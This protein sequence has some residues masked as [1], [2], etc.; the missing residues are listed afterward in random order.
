MIPWHP[1]SSRKEFLRALKFG[2]RS[3]GGHL[4]LRFLRGGAGLRIGFS[5]KSGFKNAARRN[6]AKRWMREAVRAS[7]ALIPRDASLVLVAKPEMQRAD[8]HFVAAEFRA[9]L[10][11]V[12]EKD[13]TVLRNNRQPIKT[14]P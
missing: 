9:L 10:A 11:L 8:F 5:T 1:L 3:E 14:N 12:L 2:E 4:F 6:R 7:I 13:P